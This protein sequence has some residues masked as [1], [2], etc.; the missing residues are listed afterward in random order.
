M[1]VQAIDLGYT[2]A[3]LHAIVYSE[4]WDPAQDFNGCNLIQ[5]DLHPFLPCFIHDYRYIVY[6]G[7]NTYDKEFK[8]N[9]IKSGFSNFRAW[10]FYLGVRLGW[11]FY[12]KWK[13]S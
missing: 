5:D 11:Y 4:E 1:K 13:L 12:Y 10:S 3:D 6:G 2:F 9:L 8:S 7:G